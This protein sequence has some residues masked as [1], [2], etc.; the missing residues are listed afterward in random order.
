MP[1]FIKIS[2]I[3]SK[4]YDVDYVLQLTKYI[5]VATEDPDNFY[6]FDS[7]KD[8]SDDVLP[9]EDIDSGTASADNQHKRRAR[10]SLNETDIKSED[11][12]DQESNVE[13]AEYGEHNESYLRASVAS[14]RRKLTRP[15]APIAES[16][17]ASDEDL[18]QSCLATMLRIERDNRRHQERVERSLDSL[19]RTLSSISSSMQTSGTGLQSFLAGVA[20]AFQRR[21]IKKP[22]KNSGSSSAV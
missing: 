21:S 14:K 15:C 13:N 2:C 19:N 7:D 18:Q 12:I 10:Y 1:T 4:S 9:L 11:F 5:K 8:S 6:A 22:N 17:A 16:S 3:P 20:Q